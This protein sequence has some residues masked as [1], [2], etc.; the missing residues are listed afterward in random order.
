MLRS[1]LAFFSA[2]F[3]VI[4]ASAQE[5]GEKYKDMVLI[6]AG[7]FLMGSTKE[8]VKKVTES[9]NG[10]KPWFGNETPQRSVSLKAFY[11]DKYEVTNSQYKKFVD[12]TG[13]RVPYVSEPWAQKYNWKDGTYPP[14]PLGMG[15][16]P[17]VLVSYEDAL[18]YA[19][20]AGKRL[21][22][23][24]E[25][26]KAARG[27]DGRIYPWGNEWDS[28]RCNSA[29][30]IFGRPVITFNQTRIWEQQFKI[31]A[32]FS[33]F[34]DPVGKYESG[35][36][37]YGCY[38]MAGNVWEWTSDWYEPYPGSSYITEEYGKTYKVLRGGSWYNGRIVLRCPNR[39]RSFPSYRS[40][41][42]GFRCAK[43]VK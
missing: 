11:I 7:E 8:Q 35:K 30:R 25:W 27:T 38:D 26:E 29:E 32:A 24:A 42:F 5:T 39:N 6:P 33:V 19:K 4:P 9:Y 13:Y 18:A 36:S 1:W 31:K 12:A 22:T 43:D 2:V 17:V 3:L 40:A 41:N 15:R 14:Y 23:E 28:S 20:W 16:R 34:T 37:P 21:P 10:K